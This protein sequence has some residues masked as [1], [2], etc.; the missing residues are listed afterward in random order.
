MAG[1]YSS[2]VRP[3]KRSATSTS[4]PAWRSRSAASSTPC[5]TPRTEWNSAT[6]AMGRAKH[7]T[8]TAAR[9][10]GRKSSDAR[11]YGAAMASDPERRVLLVVHHTTSP[12][13]QALLEAALDGTRA[14]GI[15][16][17]E[18]RVR[19]ALGATVS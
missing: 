10:C 18:V 19:P 12:A 3:S 17:V 2:N 11:R 7:A 1:S 9:Q 16:G 14:D 15:E 5:R 6:V 4:W 13:T 8:V